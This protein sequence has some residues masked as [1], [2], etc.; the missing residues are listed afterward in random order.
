MA[1]DERTLAVKQRRA[2]NGVRLKTVAL[3][4]EHGGWGFLC[5]PIAVGLLV[6]PSIGGLYLA[7]SALGFFLA[8]HPLM[9]VVLN[10]KRSSPR[11]A[12]ARR[13]AT[14]Y[15][16]IG[17]ASFAAALV[18]SANRFV[19]PLLMATPLALVQ[20]AHDWSGRRRVLVS[21]V[22]GVIAI[23]SLVAGIGLCGGGSAKSSFA[24]W[25]IMIARQVPAILYVRACLRRMHATDASP[26]P[27]IAA[28]VLA[29]LAAVALAS[30]NATSPRVV[31]LF[32][33]LAVRAVVGFTKARELTAQQLGLSEI[34][35]GAM[36][37]VIVGTSTY[38]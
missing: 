5:E 10:R 11:T 38:F 1:A 22:A 36:T 29:I 35:F 2:K 18:F 27:M 13:F 37:V 4:A 6:A 16:T 32:T 7:L 8:R 3:P 34:A 20:V 24:L 17:T 31:T 30:F 28:H 23:S 26:A 9:I 21:E 12:F 33:L 19:L 14:L 25:G 15:L